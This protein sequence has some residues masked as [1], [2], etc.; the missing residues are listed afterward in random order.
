LVMSFARI[1]GALDRAFKTV[2][3]DHSA[4]VTLI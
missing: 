4:F 2:N 1:D 3:R